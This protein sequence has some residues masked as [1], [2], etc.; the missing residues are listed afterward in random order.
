MLVSLQGHEYPIRNGVPCFVE[1]D[2]YSNSFGEQWNSYLKTQLDSYTNTSLTRDR[3]AHCL[4]PTLWD[5]LEGKFILE[6]GCGAGRFTEILL[7]QKAYLYS[8]DFSRAI[9]ANV[10]NFPVTDK[11]KVYRADILNLPFEGSLPYA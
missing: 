7:K 4:G 11:H 8:V 2:N 10:Q 6:C 1:E 9:E 5:H 3:I